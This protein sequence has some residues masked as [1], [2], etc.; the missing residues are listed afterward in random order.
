VRSND[1]IL[2]AAREAEPFS[3]SRQLTI[4]SLADAFSAI[5]SYDQ[6]VKH[7]VMPQAHFDAFSR[8]HPDVLE[9]VP[10][11]GYIGVPDPYRRAT[12]WA[13]WVLVADDIEQTVIL[14]ESVAA[15]VG[16]P[17]Q[18]SNTA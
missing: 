16:P 7:V 1:E 5:E 11:S 6:Q 8:E 12:L 14:G 10:P 15:H 2:A 4:A 3:R 9:M 13:A 18:Q 17:C